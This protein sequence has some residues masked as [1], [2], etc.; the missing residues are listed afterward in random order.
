LG[1]PK[2]T[3]PR[4][5]TILRLEAGRHDRERVL[6]LSANGMFIAG[7]RSAD[8][9]HGALFIPGEDRPLE[10][11]FRAVFRRPDGI[12]VQFDAS[13]RRTRNE[14]MAYVTH[15]HEQARLQTIEARLHGRPVNLKPLS[16]QEGTRVALRPLERTGRPVEVFR[17][18]DGEPVRASLTSVDASNSRLSLLL[19]SGRG[20]P[21]AFD[22]VFLVLRQGKVAFLADTVVEATHGALTSLM[23]PERIFFPE[24]RM[25]ERESSGT[26]ML[27][28]ELDG[29]TRVAGVLQSD[30]NGLSVQVWAIDAASFARGRDIHGAI[31]TEGDREAPLGP[32]VVVWRT[33]T[34]EAGRVRI[35]LRR[36]QARVPVAQQQ[37]E[38]AN[39]NTGRLERAWGGVQHV[40]GGWLAQAGVLPGPARPT[41]WELPD[42]EGRPIVS[43]VN[44][45]FDPARPPPGTIHVVLLP[46]PFARR[47]ETLS[48]VALSLVETFRA[49][50]EHALVVRWDGINHLGESWKDSASSQ[51]GRE[52]LH[53]TLGQTVLD[54]ATVHAQ[55]RSRLGERPMPTA[56]VSFS[57]SAVAARRYLASGATGVDYWMAPMGAPDP[58]DIIR[59]SSGGVD[60]VG[61]RKRGSSLG[62]NLIQGHLLDCDRGCDEMLGSGLAEL[63]DARREMAQITQPVT[64]L[65]GNHDYWV[66]SLRV[67][68]ILGVPA[69]GSR[70]LLRVPTGHFVRQSGEAME[71]FRVI[72]SRVASRLT[73]RPLEAK[74]PPT[75]AFTRAADW[76]R[77]RRKLEAFDDQRYWSEYLKGTQRNPLGF[78][79]LA[80]TDE[81]D[82][83]M[84]EQ[85]EQ[86]G[87]QSGERLLDAGCGTGNALAAI[88]RRWGHAAPGVQID[89]IDFVPHALETA[90]AKLA[91]AAAEVGLPGQTARFHVCDLSLPVDMPVLPFGDSAFDVVLV[92]LVLPYL[93]QPARLL[94]ELSRILRPGGRLV[95][96]TLRPDCDMSGPLKRLKEKIETGDGQIKEGWR[97]RQLLLAVQDYVNAAAGL[98]EEEA[99]GRFQFYEREG[100]ESLL[101]E[102]GFRPEATTPSFGVPAQG[103]ITLAKKPNG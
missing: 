103:L 97:A 23:L 85:V 76:E 91:E 49:A 64:W 35:G 42:P 90:R 53:W 21:E 50:G 40:L 84:T 77:A 33:D 74:L 98:V 20:A 15:Q 78:D 61:M 29:Q 56:I 81:Y 19:D 44:A 63:E 2:R 68:D 3:N 8:A 48:P 32:L 14:L 73:G 18:I 80:L 6:N 55:V 102:A 54:L 86:L 24:R 52:L 67:E 100:F 83:L 36:L 34:A 69:P 51:P 92:S 89:A 39:R 30:P 5:R 59:N 95:A 101:R 94:R 31:L 26:G 88:I 60:W 27:R 45:T 1:V 7:A 58:R 11:N 62:V 10:L 46:P 65:C 43:L 66:N 25:L 37:L 75:H 17:R 41:V 4:R 28:V 47:K 96:S 71:A 38:F 9:A 99:D 57:M 79:V 16:E 13:D 22:Q 72:A 12:G 70:E 82:E 93:P 87:L